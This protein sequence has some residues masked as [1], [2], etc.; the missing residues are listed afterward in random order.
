MENRRGLTKWRRG[1]DDV[2]NVHE[3]EGGK[4]TT[5]AT[6]CIVM[7][8]GEEQRLNTAAEEGISWDKNKIVPKRNRSAELRRKSVIWA[9]SMGGESKEACQTKANDKPRN[10]QKPNQKWCVIVGAATVHIVHT[11]FSKRQRLRAA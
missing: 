8:E 10:T 2:T 9:C 3:E 5:K 1:G 7:V 4:S 6:E 11:T